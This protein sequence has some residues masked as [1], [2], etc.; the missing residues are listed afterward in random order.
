V[1]LCCNNERPDPFQQLDPFQPDPF[2]VIA[3]LLLCLGQTA[4]QQRN[5]VLQ[6]SGKT[7]GTYYH[8]TIVQGKGKGKGSRL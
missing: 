7:M 2:H 8:I 6:L 4:C 5:P 3:V 1:Q